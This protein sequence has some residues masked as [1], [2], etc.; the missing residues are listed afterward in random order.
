MIL[1]RVLVI[2]FNVAVVTFLLYRM[3]QV[4]RQPIPSARKFL[5]ILAG[6]ILLV[7]PLGIFVGLLRPNIQYF[8]IYPVAVSLFLFLIREI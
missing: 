5:V 4:A 8:L 7:A 6:L 1:I 2:A 3:F